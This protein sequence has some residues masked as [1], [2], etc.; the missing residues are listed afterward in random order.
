MGV[1]RVDVNIRVGVP[2]DQRLELLRWP[3]G[4]AET[5][6][7]RKKRVAISPPANVIAVSDRCRR[8][9]LPVLG[10][11]TDRYGPANSS[12]EGTVFCADAVHAVTDPSQTTAATRPFRRARRL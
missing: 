10:A 11:F 9:H 3:R 12:P 5:S 1:I 6:G 8:N 4:P 2:F 7:L